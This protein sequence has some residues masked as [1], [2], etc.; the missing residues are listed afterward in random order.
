MHITQLIHIILCF[1]RDLGIIVIQFARKITKQIDGLNQIDSQE[2]V[3]KPRD[4]ATICSEYVDNCHTQFQDWVSQ[5]D[6]VVASSNID[7]VFYDLSEYKKTVSVSKNNLEL[8][9]AR[10]VILETTPYGV[11]AMYYDA[12]KH[13]F[14]YF[15]DQRSVSYNVLNSVAMKYV[16]RYC[17]LE[18]FVDESVR[19]SPLL[20]LWRE[21]EKEEEKEKRGKM[22]DLDF[23][24]NA[25]F[26]GKK[27]S[28]KQQNSEPEDKPK[29]TEKHKNKFVYIGNLQMHFTQSYLK[30]P[31]VVK[32]EK[33][34]DPVKARMSYK[35]FKKTH[36]D[37]RPDWTIL[38][39]LP[40]EDES[41]E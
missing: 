8:S 17:C 25:P 15:C 28:S 11:V 27:T 18:L 12:Y 4:F 29:N 6:L 24:K 19:L 16:R 21:A 38:S 26:V 10:R 22:A 14:S 34:L 41:S 23:L 35:D 40:E 9:W 2:D 7:K 32:V 5:C 20:E 13:A 30:A 37:E 33:K 36:D 1:F 39:G 3:K 31:V